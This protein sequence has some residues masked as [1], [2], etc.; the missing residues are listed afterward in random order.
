MKL[1]LAQLNDLPIIMTMLQ[2]V[3]QQLKHQQLLIWDEF[4]PSVDNI[5]A[6][7][8]ENNAYVLQ[9]EQEM[10][11]YIALD[12][13]EYIMQFFPKHKTTVSFARVMID[14]KY[15]HKGYGKQL[16]ALSI[17]QI[18]SLGYQAIGILVSSE[19]VVAIALYESFGFCFLN[20]KVF[21]WGEMALYYLE[22]SP[23]KN[24]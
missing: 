21:S 8:T 23:C 6:D 20:H 5:K 10:I 13:D 1:N 9:N 2:A 24:G 14:P 3:K 4:Y 11:G 16:I 18:R 15:Q 12:T 17:Q 7:I 22:L 19:N